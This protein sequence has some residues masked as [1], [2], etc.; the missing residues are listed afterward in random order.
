MLQALRIN[1]N[2][3]K[4]YSEYLKFEVKFLDKL[5][6]RRSILNGQSQFNAEGILSK[7]EK[8]LAF[9]DDE[10]EKEDDIEGEIKRGEESNIVK[11][12]VQNLLEK[13]PDDIILLKEVKD[14]LK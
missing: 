1:E 4:F 3:P 10:D 12:V 5:M 13:F 6:H 2:V 9:I 8:D 11:I 7:K 14:I